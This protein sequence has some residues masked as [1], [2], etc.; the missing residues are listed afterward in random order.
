[1][2]IEINRQIGYFLC[3]AREVDDKRH[4]RPRNLVQAMP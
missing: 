4:R 3:H 2:T 1:M